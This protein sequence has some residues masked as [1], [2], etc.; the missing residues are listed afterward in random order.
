MEVASY[1]VIIVHDTIYIQTL[2]YLV[3]NSIESTTP[4]WISAPKIYSPIPWL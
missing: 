1:K 2:T 4:F 3:H